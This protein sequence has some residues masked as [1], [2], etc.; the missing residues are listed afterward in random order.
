MRISV[1]IPARNATATIG[2][3][4]GSIESQTRPAD[5]VIVVDDGSSDNLSA[6]LARRVSS[7]KLIRI[8]R[9][10]AARARNVGAEQAVGD[11]L[12]FCDADLI[13]EPLILQ[14]LEQALAADPQ[15]AFAYCSFLAWEGAVFA[16]RAFDAAAL[17]RNNYISTMSLIRRAAFP[18]F[19]EALPRFQ[20]WD[21]WLTV[22][23]RGGYGVWVPEVLFRVAERGM[24]SR[25]GGLSR[26]RATALIRSKHRLRWYWSD[27]WLAFKE[28]VRSGRL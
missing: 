27:L 4:L 14:K 23:E 25:R 7:V 10:G 26:L 3:T 24:I 11:A 16:N 15:A 20:D 22:I 28:S 1:I 5:E 2:D 9:A 18:G 17:R 12:F 13:L 21:L 8:E 19:D 6:E